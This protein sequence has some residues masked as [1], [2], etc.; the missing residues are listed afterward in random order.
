[1]FSRHGLSDLLPALLCLLRGPHAELLEQHVQHKELG[2]PGIDGA[3]LERPL[4]GAALEHH[5]R[6]LAPGDLGKRDTSTTFTCR[7]RATSSRS[8]KSRVEPE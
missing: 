4:V 3:G 6:Q 2:H 5:I 8:W 7:C 1:M